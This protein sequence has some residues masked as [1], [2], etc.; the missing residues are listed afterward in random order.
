VAET[1][2]N[3]QFRIENKG[4]YPQPFQAVKLDVREEKISGDFLLISKQ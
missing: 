2:I 1:M 3:A 4:H